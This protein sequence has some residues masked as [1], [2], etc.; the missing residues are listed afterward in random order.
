MI[1]GRAVV[2]RSGTH[3]FAQVTSDLARARATELLAHATHVSRL[4]LQTTAECAPG[5]ALG[6]ARRAYKAP[7]SPSRAGRPPARTLVQS[8]AG[9]ASCLFGSR[10]SEVY[11]RLYD[12]GVESGWA[13]PG[14]IWRWEVELKGDT[15]TLTWN[16]LA[17]VESIEAA[18]AAVVWQRF[19]LWG[20][21][22]PQE[23]PASDYL[24]IGLASEPDVTRSLLWLRTQ[25]RPT[26]EWLAGSGHL[27]EVL[28]ALNLTGD[29]H[30]G[31]PPFET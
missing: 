3:V 18:A 17:Q 28:A 23:N 22:P 5:A 9:G 16:E 7:A 24:R 1:A 10:H 30:P 31:Q 25:V 21:P 14:T 15:A 4:D 20:S 12:K 2:A 29:S 8:Q 19:M 27:Q 26:V 11:G 6:L 13:V